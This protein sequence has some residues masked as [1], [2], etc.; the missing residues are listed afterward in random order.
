MTGHTAGVLRRHRGLWILAAVVAVALA[1][2]AASWH[3]HEH[4]GVQVGDRFDGVT[5]FSGQTTTARMTVPVAFG[6]LAVTVGAGAEV[7]ERAQRVKAPHG[8]TM[9]EVSWSPIRSFISPPVWPSSSARER[10]DP[11]AE[12]I[13]MTGGHRYPIAK[14]VGVADEGAS[15]VVVVK[16][17]GTDARLET[18]F[19]GRTF[20]SIAGAAERRMPEGGGSRACDDR[21]EKTYSWVNCTLP[22]HRSVYVAGLGAAPEGKEWLLVSGAS[23]TREKRPINVYDEAE[24]R[25]EYVPSGAPKVSITVDGI[26]AEPRVAG[27]DDIAGD[28]VRVADRAWLVDSDKSS[29]VRL[30]YRLATKID[31]SR[32]DRP[33]APATYEVDVSTTTTYPAA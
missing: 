21:R 25:A 1:A 27:A 20:R 6:A 17:D 3:M 24:S 28:T 9:M 12:L 4:H 22:V 2:A 16:G 5:V 23:A 33:D 31:R 15:A 29:S 18:R 32:S 30:R 10:R 13:L 7:G 26:T 8:A 19:S 11:G 14:D